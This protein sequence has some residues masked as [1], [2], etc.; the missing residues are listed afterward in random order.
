MA[1]GEKRGR[2]GEGSVNPYY[3]GRKYPE[4]T[5]CPRCG[6]LY[7]N[8]R[9]QTGDL[10]EDELEVNR[11]HCPACRREIDRIPGG[12]IRLSGGYLVEHHDEI[13]NIV[14]NQA[15]SAAENRP[16]QRIM[17]IEEKE[18]ATEIATTNGHLATRIGKAIVGACKGSLTIKR[19]RED[20]LTRV[21]WERED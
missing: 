21:Y 9:W 3:E 10:E 20:Q 15:A 14:R 1:E 19:G 6:L 17:W 12:V 11:S 7:K 13:L 2:L 5:V 16:L 18:D 4:P 8:G